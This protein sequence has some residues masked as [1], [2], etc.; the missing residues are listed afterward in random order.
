MNQTSLKSCVVVTCFAENQPGYLDFSYRIRAL[1]TNYQLTLVSNFQL[2]QTELQYPNVNYVVIDGGHGWLGWI[3]Y[4][5]RCICLIRRQRPGLAV[6]LH[7]MLSPVAILIGSIPTITYWNEHPTHIAPE[8][9][10]FAPLV[11]GIRAAIR[12]LMFQGARLSSLVMPIGEAHRDD[13]LSHGCT[14]DKT[15]LIYMGVEESFVGV[16][17]PAGS[18]DPA[19]PIR[20]VYVGS[21]QKDRGRDVML[22]AM[23][24]ANRDGRIAQLT[25]V[26]AD[27]GQLQYC[28][29]AVQRLGIGNA[30]TIYGRVP[31]DRIPGFLGEADAGLCLWEDLPWYRFNPPTKLFEYLVA[32]LPV[33]ASDIRTHTQYVR[34]GENGLIFE[35]GSAGLAAAIRRIWALREDLPRMKLRA[36]EAS[37]SYRWSNI[38]PVFLKAASEAAK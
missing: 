36:V 31:G 20:L 18:R 13:L 6:L 1:A 22:E 34:D 16:A 25:I 2:T 8:P 33:L 15:R 19:A 37:S 12:W 35:Y 3:R 4:L 21:V 32:G 9:G 38:E 29:Q 17:D 24:L 26:G 30:V 10:R 5:W 28:Q 11:A 27:A 7:S 14:T 23:A